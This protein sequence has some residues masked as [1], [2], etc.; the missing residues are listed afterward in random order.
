MSE[1]PCLTRARTAVPRERLEA[2]LERLAV[3]EPAPTAWEDA[4]SGEAWV[5]FCDPDPRVVEACCREGERQA[6]L[7]GLS[8]APTVESLE[9]ADWTEAWKRF[10]HTTRISARLTVHP[11]WEPYEPAVGERLIHID[12]GMSFG[13]GLHPT[14][15]SCLRALDALTPESGATGRVLV[16]LGCGSGILAIAAARLGWEAIFALDHDPQ[17]VRIAGENLRL[18]DVEPS[19]VECREADVLRDP[20]PEGDLVLANILAPVLIEAAPRIAACLRPGRQCALVL[21]GILVSQYDE[22]AAAYRALGL[23]EVE[24]WTEGEWRSGRFEQARPATEPPAP[25]QSARAE[26]RW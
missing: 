24:A 15:R 4:D 22:V 2:L 26:S 19:R 9:P 1:P 5:E 14:T 12:P 3:L 6:R 18:N 10:F 7:L 13:T 8:W 11:V 21:S 20:L 23:G 25:S 16:D 17:A